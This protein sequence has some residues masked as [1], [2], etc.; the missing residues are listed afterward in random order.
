MVKV[1]NDE[2]LILRVEESSGTNVENSNRTGAALAGRVTGHLAAIGIITS[3]TLQHLY[4]QGF[5]VILPMIYTS[6]GLTP[7]AAGFIGTIRQV[8][9]GVVSMIGGFVLDKFQHRRI[10][11]LFLSL[12]LMGLGYLLVGLSPTYPLILLS[13][14]L[15]GAAGSIW[16]PAA[17]G[18]LSQRYPERRGFM[19]ALHRS[20]GNI[21]DVLGP[22]LVGALLLVLV[23]QKILFGAFPIAVAMALL[24]WTAL[25]RA[26][27]WQKLTDQTTTQRM[28]G[29]QFGALKEV[30][31]SRALILLLLVSG[32][33][34]LGQGS[35]MLWLPLYLQETQGM[36]SFGIGMHLGL[37]SGVGIASVPVIGILSDRLGRN[38]VILIVLL[39]QTTIAI[40]M[41]LA[42]SG[43]ILT[44]LVGF[45]GAFLFAL[46]PLLQAGA[47]DIAEGKRLESSMIGLLW[48]INAA[49][50]GVSPVIVGFLI[51]SLGYSVLF[52]YIAA[53]T[54][55]AG[56]LSISIIL[57]ASRT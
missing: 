43:I 54:A 51:T 33:S 32:I 28:L 29:E 5:Y 48:G 11:V 17:L 40:L 14:G 42:G 13:I 7:V 36:G 20:S 56:L 15:A 41:A 18:L 10:L 6:L 45:M 23:W 35:I 30:L 25:S 12:L 38:R 53:A 46:N 1:R 27:D 37:L 47:L 16:H 50:N 4:G 19:L 8:I 3:H 9:S 21:G 24:L 57:S 44:I 52:W 49:F 2:S 34:G 22:L 55:I 31:K 39:A 26:G